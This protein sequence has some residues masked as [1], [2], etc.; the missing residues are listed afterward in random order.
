M[1]KQPLIS[2]IT[3]VYN[4]GGVLGRTVAS[5]K[6]QG[7]SRIEYIIVDGGST[8]N[9]MDIVRANQDVIGKWVSEP[10]KGLYD[11][12][13]KGI[14]MAGGDYLW[15]IN[16]GDEIFDAEVLSSIFD[17]NSFLSDVYYGETMIIDRNG[18]EIGMRRLRA[19]EK[20]TWKNLVN[21]MVVCHQSFIARKEI[22]PFYDRQY[23]IAADYAWML[24]TLRKSGTVTN[25]RLI[26]SRFLD[27]GLNKQQIPLALAER[28]RIMQRHFGFLRTVAVHF[29]IAFRFLFYVVRNRRF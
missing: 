10:D 12:M 17:N 14:M 8:D 18:R 4:A 21:G 2:I 20:L 9:T 5:I 3:V 13:N 28:F 15:F 1:N 16:A 24:E 27:G 26:L 6:K 22:A 19:P 7:Y 11:A 29:V 23:K 25:T